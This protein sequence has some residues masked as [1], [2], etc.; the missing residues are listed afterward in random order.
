MVQKEYLQFTEEAPPDE[1][2]WS[3]VLADVEAHIKSAK[4]MPYFSIDQPAPA[5]DWKWAEKIYNRDEIIELEATGYNRGGLLVEDERVKGFVPISHLLEISEETSEE[6]RTEILASYLG[7]S[8]Q[9]KVIECSAKRERVVLSERAAQAAP[10][11]RLE[12]LK[13]LTTGAHIKGRVTTIT[14]FGVFVDLGGIEGLIHISELSW[15]R[16]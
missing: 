9:L 5:I 6:K 2:W 13:R 14:H 16:V 3:A 7:C 11:Q 15:G 12:L 4:D 1:S 10:G 8:L